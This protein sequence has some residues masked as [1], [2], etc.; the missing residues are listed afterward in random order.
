MSSSKATKASVPIAA[1]LM[2][3]GGIKSAAPRLM[4]PQ[5]PVVRAARRSVMGGKMAVVTSWIVQEAGT[6]CVVCVGGEGVCVTGPGSSDWRVA[7]DNPQLTRPPYADVL[8]RTTPH[9][10]K[11]GITSMWQYCIPGR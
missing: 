7:V 11:T 2:D 1:G 10:T 8:S 5:T 9:L 4:G 3:S 6:H